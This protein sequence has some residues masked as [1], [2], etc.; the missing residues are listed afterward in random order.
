M[1]PAD[2]SSLSRLAE[3]P[4]LVPFVLICSLALALQPHGS[5]MGGWWSATFGLA[6]LVTLA[7]K[8]AFLGWGIG[9]AALDF[10][11]IS[12]HAMC[13]A[14]VYPTLLVAVTPQA[15]PRWRVPALVA[16]ALLALLIGCSRVILGAHS[17]S[18]VLAGLVLGGVAAALTLRFASP[19]TPRLPA[20][21]LLVPCAALLAVPAPVSAQASHGTVVR[22]ALALSGRTVPYTR[23]ELRRAHALN[24]A[25]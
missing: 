10:T 1:I 25:Q 7:T 16:G 6:G 23:A 21:L 17:G 15:H 9:S 19:R 18:E 12:G 20:L 2:W 8:V 22:L 24:A 3:A 5:R 4:I 11:G 14:A 13:A